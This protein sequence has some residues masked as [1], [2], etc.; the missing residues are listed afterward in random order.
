MEE[1][2]SLGMALFDFT[3]VVFFLMGGLYLAKI[4]FS[5]L[6]K[7]LGWIFIS[8]V[9]LIFLG[10]ALQATWKLLY[11][12]NI[13]DIQWMSKAQFVLMAIGFI[14]MLI[15]ILYL[16]RSDKGKNP[17]TV[18]AMA[19]WK[20]PLLII[21]TL[22]SLGVYATLALIAT[23]RHLRWT[24]VGFMIPFFGVILMGFLASRSQTVG[25]QWIEQSLNSLKN[26]SFAISSYILSKNVTEQAR[27]E[28]GP[29][30]I[31]RFDV[32]WLVL[33]TFWKLLTEMR[34]YADQYHHHVRHW[35]VFIW[36]NLISQGGN[37]DCFTWN[38]IR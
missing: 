17:H 5:S 23:R 4:V 14:G 19:L 16:A 30:R 11:C 12:L 27:E 26:I 6:Q 21:M 10:G 34:R 28:S 33:F 37:S 15:P 7:C 29:Y 31:K 18:V 3:P 36:L 2:Y 20:I 32:L 8:S 35:R 25:L 38:K 9:L 1:T 13:C 22:A 24:A